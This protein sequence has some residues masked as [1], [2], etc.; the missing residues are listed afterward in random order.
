M[1]DDLAPTE[2]KLARAAAQKAR[3]LSD[4]YQRAH[5]NADGSDRAVTAR[6]DELKRL[7]TEASAKFELARQQARGAASVKRR[8]ETVLHDT[9]LQ[10]QLRAESQAR[11]D[12]AAKTEPPERRG[13]R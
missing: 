3:A 13:Y 11:R 5:R 8:Q 9:Q 1:P 10:A 12:A 7:A 6:G 4:E 2:V